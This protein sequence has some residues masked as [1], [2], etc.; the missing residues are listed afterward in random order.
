MDIVIGFSRAKSVWKIGSKIIAESEKRNYS[1][2]YIKI[3]DPL[4]GITLVY[5]ASLGMVNVY[6][7]NLFLEH[8]IV[9][10]EYVMR[11]N[12]TQYKKVLTF[13]H[14]NVGKPYSKDQ[15]FFLT[16]KKLLG[17]EVKYQNK[18]EEFVCSELAVRIIEIVI[19]G[20]TYDTSI[21]YVTPS[22]LNRLINQ[23]NLPK[24]EVA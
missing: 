6:N 4:T 3:V 14:E 2:A 17:F 18:D 23:L 1:H 21:D 11:V 9:A 24:V 19:P 7:Y 10:E 5:Q 12:Q 15:I 20:T 22:D 8:N 13:L 16:I